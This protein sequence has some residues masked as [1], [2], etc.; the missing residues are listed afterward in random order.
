MK[1]VIKSMIKFVKLPR[2]LSLVCAACL[3][4]L[5]SF[6][7][8][9]Q[10]LSPNSTS[11]S[12]VLNEKSSD[13]Q[14]TYRNLALKQNASLQ[15]SSREI[16]ELAAKVTKFVLSFEYAFIEVQHLPHP[17]ISDKK[18]SALAGCSYYFSRMSVLKSQA[19][20]PT[21]HI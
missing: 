4:L 3:L 21:M 12:Y 1:Q 14:L 6:S 16:L 19:H 15:H 17:G 11:A 10:P 18:T 9:A 13:Q 8:V 7:V 5:V 20:P 2:Q